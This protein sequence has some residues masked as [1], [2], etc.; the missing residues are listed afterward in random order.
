MTLVSRTSWSR[1]RQ[2]CSIGVAQDASVGSRS[3]QF[4]V[5]SN[6]SVTSSRKR[7]GQLSWARK[8]VSACGDAASTARSERISLGTAA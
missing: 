4:W 1:F 5:G 2:T 8:I 3:N 7:T 6:A